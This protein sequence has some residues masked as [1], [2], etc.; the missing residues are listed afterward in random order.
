VPPKQL[1]LLN[2]RR[3]ASPPFFFC[4]FGVS[5]GSINK[6]CSNSHPF[7][8]I[9]ITCRLP[10]S[11][12][13]SIVQKGGI[14]FGYVGFKQMAVRNYDGVSLLART[15]INRSCLPDRGDA[16]DVRGEEG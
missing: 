2:K 13:T 10:A 16:D 3:M 12:Y 5:Q 8:V 7:L 14:D 11:I 4:L 15:V 6:K 1:T 9:F